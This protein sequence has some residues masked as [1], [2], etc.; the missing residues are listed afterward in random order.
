MTKKYHGFSLIEL[1][2]AVLL[3]SITVLAAFQLMTGTSGQF[4]D[5]NERRMLNANLR[6]AELILQRDISRTAYAVGYD[7][8]KSE[9]NTCETEGEHSVYAADSN[10]KAGLLAFK[11]NRDNHFANMRIVAS[12]SDYAGFPLSGASNVKNPQDA[13]FDPTL[14]LPLVARQVANGNFKGLTVTGD[15]FDSIFRAQFQN[16]SAIEITTSENKSI[17]VETTGIADGSSTVLFAT[18]VDTQYCGIDATQ[19]FNGDTALPIIAINYTVAGNTLYRCVTPVFTQDLLPANPVNIESNRVP[20]GWHCEILIEGIQYFDIY[21]IATKT[22]NTDGSQIYSDKF[23]GAK[24][25][26]DNEAAIQNLWTSVNY[27]EL[28]GVAYRFGAIS[29]NPAKDNVIQSQLD[30]DL[31]PLL[32]VGDKTYLYAHANGSITFRTPRNGI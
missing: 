16:A 12:I 1:L 15:D 31:P 22:I 3:T 19:P 21:P 14:S 2:V 5:E 6:N 32:K 17:I 18:P 7:S 29:T 20:D 4:N 28:T 13:I 25:G 23:M 30:L 9:R 24:P 8:S 10:S 26:A 27:D 11:Q